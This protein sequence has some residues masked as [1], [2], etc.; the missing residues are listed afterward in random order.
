MTLQETTMVITSAIQPPPQEFHW[1]VRIQGNCTEVS[2]IAN[3][4]KTPPGGARGRV[5]DFTSAAR[6]RMMRFVAKIDW[7]SIGKS[8]FIT[9]T[10]PD[11]VEEPSA[12]TRNNNR[13]L[14]QRY[15]EKHLKAKVPTLWRV[16]WK[17]RQSGRNKGKIY[18]HIHLLVGGVQFVP[19]RAVRKWWRTIVHVNGPLCTDVQLVDGDGA[20]QAYICKYASKK[21]SLDIVAYLNNLGIAGRH[22]G[23]TRKHLFTMCPVRVL[24]KISDEQAE[25]LRGLAACQF[26]N[27]DPLLGGG[28]TFLGSIHA[29]DVASRCKEM[30]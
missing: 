16:E 4:T 8:L 30:C 2:R 29:D 1:Y 10:Y 26:P 20:A 21:A 18:P 27:Y 6:M 17:P 28:F 22:W 23:I 14:F 3:F 7:L 24:Q 11:Q 12:K 5:C 19:H 15:L 25:E 13:Y 9:L